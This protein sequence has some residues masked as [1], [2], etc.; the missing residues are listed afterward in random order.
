MTDAVKTIL[1][2]NFKNAAKNLTVLRDEEH[3]KIGDKI[4]DFIVEYYD[5]MG[6]IT[7]GGPPIKTYSRITDGASYTLLVDR[8]IFKKDLVRY[9]PDVHRGILV[10]IIE[11]DKISLCGITFRQPRLCMGVARFEVDSSGGSDFDTADIFNKAPKAL[12]MKQ[13]TEK[14]I[15]E[16]INKWLPW[17]VRKV[18]EYAQKKQEAAKRS[19]AYC[20][21]HTDY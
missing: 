21:A 11:K 18:A 19:P 4:S 1:N 15:L 12:F 2:K 6:S 3:E 17:D 13:E 8:E 9:T 16:S 20:P 7:D 5:V 14:D 10:R